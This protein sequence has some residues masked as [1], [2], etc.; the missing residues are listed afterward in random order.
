MHHKYIFNPVCTEES[1]VGIPDT[2]ALLEVD[3]SF[4]R[5]CFLFKIYILDKSKL[6]Q[7]KNI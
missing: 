2:A 6:L 4:L 1:G 5:N 7:I 3:N